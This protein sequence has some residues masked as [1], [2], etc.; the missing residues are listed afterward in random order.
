MKSN[1]YT[2]YNVSTQHILTRRFLITVPK[3]SISSDDI[4]T[5]IGAIEPIIIEDIPV[6]DGGINITSEY[7]ERHEI[8]CARPLPSLETDKNQF[9]FRL[10]QLQSI[11]T[12]IYDVI[13]LNSKNLIG[14][15]KTCC[16]KKLYSPLEYEG[17]LL[18][19]IM[20]T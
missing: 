6:Q 11:N 4:K 17:F 1:T 14:K 15:I 10:V 16:I 5:G 12:R 8:F 20:Q 2:T 18:S 19:C 13:K 7:I 9:I 3:N